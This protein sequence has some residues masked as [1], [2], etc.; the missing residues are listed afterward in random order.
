MQ[1]SPSP[2]PEHDWNEPMAERINNS[3]LCALLSA[4]TI[5]GLSGQVMAQ[6]AGDIGLRAADGGL[7]VYGP[8]G[9]DEDTDGVYLATF[10]D[11]G[12][13]GYTPNPG[14]DAL[15]GSFAPG[16]IGFN[17]L[18]GL[19]RWD[20]ATTSW[21]APSDVEE[22]L[23]I[24]FITLQTMIEDEAVEGF[25]LAI[26]PDGG[27]HRHMNF[28]LLSGASGTRMNGIYRFDLVLYATQG[29]EDSEPFTILFDYNADPQDVDDAIDSMY[30]NAPCLGDI[31]GSGTVD[32]GDLTTLLAEWGQLSETADLSGDGFVGGEDLTILLG[33]WGA[34][35]Q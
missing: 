32:G 21:L 13:E 23:S 27:W 5:G 17:A 31:D 16:R 4:G 12:F 34:C 9:A 35:D 15:P 29:L 25:D 28:E 22:R 1:A 3:I 11:T 7:E 14:F 26:Q 30:E 33:R 24:S 19:M 18:S 10:G 8:I 6:H 20:P 2:N